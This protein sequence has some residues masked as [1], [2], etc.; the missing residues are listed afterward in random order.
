[1]ESGVGHLPVLAVVAAIVISL[2]LRVTQT[3]ITFPQPHRKDMAQALNKRRSGG[4][5][6]LG[7]LVELR[8]LTFHPFFRFFFFFFFLF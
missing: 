6:A 1:M 5:G 4:N 7:R 2:L 3:N 8:L